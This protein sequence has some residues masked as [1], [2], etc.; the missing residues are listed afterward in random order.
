MKNPSLFNLK[1]FTII[2]CSI[3]LFSCSNNDIEASIEEIP[4]EI[5]VCGTDVTD[6]GGTICCVSGPVL[7]SPGEKLTYKYESNIIGADITWSVY[8]G[9]ITLIEGEHLSS[10]T[11]EFNSD[12]TSGEIRGYAK[13]NVICAEVIS[14][15]KK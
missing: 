8:S 4:E 10:A 1:I 5:I 11:F 3:C 6:Y 9:S 13:G 7:A 2:I 12:F 14:I 15:S